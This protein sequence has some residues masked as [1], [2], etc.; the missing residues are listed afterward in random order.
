MLWIFE[1]AGRKNSNNRKY[2][3]WQQHNKPIELSDNKILDQKLDYLHMNP[4]EEGFV[5]EVHEF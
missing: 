4:V 2:Q 5:D 3:F 1:R